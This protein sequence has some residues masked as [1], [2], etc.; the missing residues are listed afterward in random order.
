MSGW[1]VAGAGFGV[2]LLG[3]WLLTLRKPRSATTTALTPAPDMALAP[4]AYSPQNVGNDASARPWEQ[5]TLDKDKAERAQPLGA[6]APHVGSLTGAPDDF[7]ASDFLDASRQQFL[8]LQTA[9]DRSDIS[10]VRAWLTTAMLQ[11]IE[12]QL[13]Q[14]EQVRSDAVATE[15]VM[16]DAQLLGLETTEQ[17]W[18]AS[19]E[20]SGLIREH[21]S[22]GPSP[23]R[24]L[25]SIS[26]ARS[27]DG[28]W[29]VAGVQALQ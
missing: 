16:L 29:L 5:S 22:A 19:V 21:A 9:W 18:V 13:D 23:F 12:Q 10:T 2:V 6:A 27:G 17:D 11:Q 1:W 28:R 14:R 20:F 8:A 7:D 24:E 26:R 25:W 15:V 4:R 3:V